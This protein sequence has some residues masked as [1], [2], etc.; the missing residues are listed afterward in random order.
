MRK[1]CLCIFK[2]SLKNPYCIYL[3]VW[4]IYSAQVAAVTEGHVTV[5]KIQWTHSIIISFA[6]VSPTYICIWKFWH[7]IHK[8]W[9]LLVDLLLTVDN[10]S[11]V[12][13]PQNIYRQRFLRIEIVNIHF[14]YQLSRLLAYKKGELKTFFFLFHSSL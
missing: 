1:I 14:F 12:P 10:S 8:P 3:R 9:A 5:K 4:W 13:L 6:Y 11:T 2:K 7:L